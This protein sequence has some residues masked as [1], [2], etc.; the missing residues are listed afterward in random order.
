MANETTNKDI[1]FI[2]L[3]TN[4]D[5]YDS[6]TK[7]L[8][9]K[10][11]DAHTRKLNVQIYS[12]GKLFDTS[13]FSIW[14]N[15]KSP[16]Q[17]SLRINGIKDG[18]YITFDLENEL[19]KDA[20]HVACDISLYKECE[21]IDFVTSG[22]ILKNNV[23]LDKTAFKNK[24]ANKGTY[25]FVFT[26]GAWTLDNTE[27]VLSD[28]GITISKTP[29]E[30]DC[31]RVSYSSYMLLT[32]ET[33]YIVVQ[34]T[35]YDTNASEAITVDDDGMILKYLDAAQV[36]EAIDKM[37]SHANKN[38]LDN[39]TASYT[40]EEKIKLEG[41][42]SSDYIFVNTKGKPNGVATL[43]GSG[44]V[45]SAQLPS[46][47]DDVIDAYTRTS[48]TQF[49]SD[50]L[51]LSNNG[52]ALTPEKGKIYLIIS[53]GS[54]ANKQYRWSGTTYVLCNPSDVNS[55]N[56]KTGIVQ[57]NQD[58]VGDGDTY[59]R[60]HNDFTNELKQKLENVES[61]AEVNIQS[62][63]NQT[64]A[65]KDDYIKNKPLIPEGSKMYDTTGQNT[66]GS[67][68]QKAATDE[69][70]K[71][72]P[73]TG[74]TMT[75]NIIIPYSSGLKTPDGDVLLLPYAGSDGNP[76][77]FYISEKTRNTIINGYKDRPQYNCPASGVT[78]IALLSDL[79]S[80]LP[81]SGGKMTGRISFADNAAIPETDDLQFIAGIESYGAG[82]GILYTNRDKLKQKL[83][84]TNGAIIKGRVQD[85]GDD[86]GLIIEKAA[87][88][89]AGLCLGSPT[90]A[91]SVHY[92]T[93]DN[94]AIWRWCSGDSNNFDIKHPQKAGTI[95][96]T[97]D[98][99]TKNYTT[100][101]VIDA[102][103]LDENTYYPVTFDAS[104]K[105]LKIM[106]FNQW[107][108]GNPSWATHSSKN[109]SCVKIWETTG[110]GWGEFGTYRRIHLS[111]FSQTETDPVRGVGQLG[112][113]STEYVYVRGGGKYNFY[114]SDNVVPVLRTSTYTVASQSIAPTTTAP[115]EIRSNTTSYYGT[116]NEINLLV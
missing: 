2:K 15:T 100:Y 14:L 113:S 75:G 42:N 105:N 110:H 33:F 47:V 23:T 49:A 29:L 90:G 107:N 22:S 88:N 41:L 21:Y 38:V 92:L 3:E 108:G 46:F 7:A 8:F 9:A 31:V 4:P 17:K 68:T 36:K 55:V 103:T 57:L 98:I 54:F 82:G 35:I 16:S 28:Y 18:D 20:G 114:T 61:G 34:E 1:K 11:N 6:Y 94:S 39:I 5:H 106:L 85:S 116:F 53:S 97:S 65:T 43:D 111:A 52:V 12:C 19:L 81:L 79:N 26:D 74:G 77:S 93:P 96:L 62:D 27:V 86:E 80:Y 71:Y 115:D 66:D 37:H 40:S 58:D 109:Y 69:F 64:D 95:A 51:S 60:T 67:M 63:W 32:T 70:A 10:Q 87:N 83:L 24:V 84:Q 99:S 76:G 59:V 25:E 72:L 112:N 91:R 102:T 89:Y 13:G 78:D 56:G 44:L 101:T 45:P 73:L 30:T 48:A 50:W 104:R